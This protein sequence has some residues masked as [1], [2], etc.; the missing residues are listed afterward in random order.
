[1]IIVTGQPRSGTSMLMQF[2]K[3]GG[4]TLVTDN[5]RK[6]DR[7]NPKGYQETIFDK[8]TLRKLEDNPTGNV[9]KVTYPKVKELTKNHQYVFITRDSNEILMSQEDMAET[10][11]SLSYQ[12]TIENTLR[13]AQD[14]FRDKECIWIDYK[15]TIKDPRKELYPLKC[16]VCDWKKA[17]R[18][19]D[20]KLYRYKAHS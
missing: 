19:V 4:L 20:E 1:M 5:K 12:I 10:K 2:F 7:H 9:L 8:D 13:E 18:A 14:Y 6:P 11:Y 16:L 15:K 17:W 3:A